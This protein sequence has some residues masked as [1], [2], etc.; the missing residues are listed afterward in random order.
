VRK[1]RASTRRSGERRQTRTR[2]AEF[3]RPLD[4]AYLLILTR[5]PGAAA[6]AREMGITQRRLDQVL[7][8]LEEDLEAIGF[9][10]VS[11]VNGKDRA[12][13]FEARGANRGRPITIGPHSLRARRMPPSPP[14]LKPEDEIIYARD[15]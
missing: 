7:R 14:G 1:R 12:L 6:L 2:A 5:R 9:R 10:T 4:E 15:W 3:D 8:S 11:V 13:R